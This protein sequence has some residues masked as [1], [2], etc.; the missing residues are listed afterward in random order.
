MD[1]WRNR[2]AEQLLGNPEHAHDGNRPK[3]PASA[4]ISGVT[5][6]EIAFGKARSELTYVLELGRAHHLPI[7]GSVVGDEVWIRLGETK[8]VFQLDRA[9]PK[10][11]AKAHG[12][13][14]TRMTWD[15]AS[16]AIVTDGN[17]VIDVEWFVRDAIDATVRAWK[18]ESAAVSA[19]DKTI[20][21][22][23]M[24]DDKE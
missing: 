23:T 6:M 7:V 5:A 3:A 13:S 12:R 21:T 2:L 14:D 11:T 20:E 22:N 9:T 18:A 19:A 10:V 24:P 8:L 16:R 15:A 1:E 17:K 4:M